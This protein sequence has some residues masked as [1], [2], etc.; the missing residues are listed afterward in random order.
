[1]K[2]SNRKRLSLIMVLVLVLSLSLIGCSKDAGTNEV[3]DLNKNV[4]ENIKF[5][6]D[7][8]IVDAE[9]LKENMEK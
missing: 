2:E 7:T 5:E 4:E 3:K 9:W 1:M 6:D 8:Y